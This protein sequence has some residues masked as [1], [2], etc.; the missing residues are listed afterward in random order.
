LP[1]FIVGVPR[2]GLDRDRA[3]PCDPSSHSWR[4][5]ARRFLPTEVLTSLRRNFPNAEPNSTE[6]GCRGSASNISRA[7]AQPHDRG[8]GAGVERI[9]DK[10]LA[11]YCFAGLIHLALPNAHIIHCRRDPVDTACRIFHSCS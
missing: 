2:F 9:T 3:R 5:R 4:R 7:F 6:H 8:G 1:I 10:M 11:N